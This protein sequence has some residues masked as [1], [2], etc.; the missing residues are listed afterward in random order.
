M[1]RWIINIDG[2]DNE[3]VFIP[4]HFSAKHKLIINGETTIIKLKNLEGIVGTDRSIDIGGKECRL[5]LLGTNAEIAVDGIYVGSR[6]PYVPLKSMPWWNWI[7]IIAC[8]AIPI[9][10]LGGVLPTIFGIGG[11]FSCIRVS[12][13]PNVKMFVKIMLCLGITAIA[14]S[15]LFLLFNFINN[16]N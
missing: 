10:S 5:V 7:F 9:V 6:K 3:V 14:W 11:L 1:K 13:L 2:K 16:P 15:L 8:I 4:S 12:V